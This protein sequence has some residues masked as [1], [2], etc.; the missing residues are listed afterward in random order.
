MC[1]LSRISLK[2]LASSLSRRQESLYMVIS[3]LFDRL[4]AS[5]LMLVFYSRKAHAALMYSTPTGESCTTESGSVKGL[6]ARLSKAKSTTHDLAQAIMK[7]L[8]KQKT[9]YPIS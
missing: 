6:S 9:Y 7:N 1:I 3:L 5:L 4:D 2:R 8:L